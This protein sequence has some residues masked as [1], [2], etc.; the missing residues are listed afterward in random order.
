[1][2]GFSAVLAAF[3]IATGA[4]SNGTAPPPAPSPSA[5][6]PIA[7]ASAS[8][9]VADVA[10]CEDGDRLAIFVAPRSP[11]PGEPVRVI[12]V[13]EDRIEASLVIRKAD[14]ADIATTKERH[15]GPPYWWYADV[16]SASAGGYRAIVARDG[17]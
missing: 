11:A 15:G 5:P 1:M 4:C 13:S 12:A 16:P 10:R 2:R 14:G 17:K 6:E 3:A 9:R 8:D 7:S